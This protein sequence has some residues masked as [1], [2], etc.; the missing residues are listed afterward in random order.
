MRAQPHRGSSSLG[1]DRVSIGYTVSLAAGTRKVLNSKQSY[2]LLRYLLNTIFE[3]FGNRPSLSRSKKRKR[4]LETFA[5]GKWGSSLGLMVAYQEILGAPE[6]PL[7]IIT[8]QGFPETY[9][10]I[11]V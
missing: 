10:F 11:I 2:G 7:R 3:V 5:I 6:I 8:R 9:T 4:R 1:L